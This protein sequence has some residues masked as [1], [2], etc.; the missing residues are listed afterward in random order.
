MQEPNI[1]QNGSVVLALNTMSYATHGIW[2]YKNQF[3]NCVLVLG[4]L[5]PDLDYRVEYGVTCDALFSRCMVIYLISMIE[6]GDAP[7]LRVHSEKSRNDNL[8]LANYSA[9]FIV[10]HERQI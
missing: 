6:Q 10:E 2:F 9:S 5:L 8:P 1:F 4:A 3:S 7:I